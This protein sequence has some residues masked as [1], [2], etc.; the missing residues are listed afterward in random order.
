M[1][2]ENLWGSIAH[3]AMLGHQEIIP[4]SSATAIMGHLLKLQDEWRAGKWTWLADQDDVQMTVEAKVIQAL[5]MDV[6]GRMHT[7]RSRND[8][9]PLDSK[10]YTRGRLLALRE[11]V[12]KCVEAFLDKAKGR[13]EQVMVAYTHV[14]QAQPVSVAFWLTHYSA[15][16]LRDLER[17]ERAYDV[18]DMNVLGSGAIAGTSFPID[19]Q[20]TT[21]LLGFQRVH[22]HA[23]D[24]T[25]SRDFM[26]ET[27]NAN[28]VL[29]THFS[30]LA[31]ELILW[32]SWEFGTITLDDGFAMGSSMMPQKKNP[33]PLELMRGR[34]GRITGYATGGLVMMK[35]L[36]SGYNR[37]FHE[38]KELLVASLELIL[39]AAEVVPPLIETTTI[40]TKRMEEISSANFANATELANYLVHKHKQPFRHAHDIVGTLVG[41]LS[42]AGKNFDSDFAT[43]AAHL[44]E[45]GIKA[46]DEEI[47]KIL[48]PKAVMLSYNCEGGT[49]NKAVLAM[50][51]RQHEEVRRFFFFALFGS[52][53]GLSP[54]TQIFHSVGQA[55]K[56]PRVG[57]GAR[58]SR[59]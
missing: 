44:R 28:A 47:R 34:A 24:A 30:R 40:N 49:G 26:L 16:L 10:L 59:P 3:V 20:I 54:H 5:G 51:E 41:R 2:D 18:T 21:K 9:V 7:C 13:E 53:S 8:Q 38:E 58:Q 11:R 52:G 37:D 4:P 42:R 1:V 27:L 23:L 55:S 32:S 14:Q 22:E 46:S 57:S 6:G 19:R 17:L 39:R 48:S 33:G 12:A 36:P 25:S 35:G 45:H 43:C 31:E 29:Q 56:A 50:M 15:V